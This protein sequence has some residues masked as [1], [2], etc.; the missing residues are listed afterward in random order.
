MKSLMKTLT[1][2]MLLAGAVA[3]G[4]AQAAAIDF[5]GAKFDLYLGAGSGT[6]WEVVYTADFTNFTLDDSLA[7]DDY[8]YM[9]HINWKWSGFNVTKVN[10]IVGPNGTAYGD[11]ISSF[12][13]GGSTNCQGGFASDWVCLDLTPD[14]ATEG[15]YTWTFNVTFDS[16]LGEGDL[17]PTGNPLRARFVDS[18][19]EFSDLMSCQAGT[20]YN[21]CTTNEVPVPG[22]LGLLG[23]GLLGLGVVRRKAAA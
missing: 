5:Y 10:S 14:V 1:A 18:D 2:S 12:N 15:S 23:L 8:E 6:T 22:T 13:G 7:N 21:R 3:A 20:T 16:A 17:D 4:Q 19:H 11:Q 9:S